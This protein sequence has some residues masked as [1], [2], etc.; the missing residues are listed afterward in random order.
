M[1]RQDLA[2]GGFPKIPDVEGIF[3]IGDNLQDF[4][5]LLRECTDSAKCGDMGAP[6]QKSKEGP[7]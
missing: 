3:R 2:A 5:R 7:A 6:G 4:W 1:E